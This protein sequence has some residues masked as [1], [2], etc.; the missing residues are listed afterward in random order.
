MLGIVSVFA[1]S[2]I[3]QYVG[4]LDKILRCEVKEQS[5]DILF[6]AGPPM[7]LGFLIHVCLHFVIILTS[8]GK[9]ALTQCQNPGSSNSSYRSARSSIATISD[10]LGAEAD[11]VSS[12]GCN[13]L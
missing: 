9:S 4:E 2:L 7:Y 1:E 12:R 5:L 6:E 8:I 11:L 10:Y 3:D 13:L